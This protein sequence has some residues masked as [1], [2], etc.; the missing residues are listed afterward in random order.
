MRN[1][2][3]EM[4]SDLIKNTIKNLEKNQIKNIKDVY[5]S[6][7]CLVT[8][9]KSMQNFDKEIKSFLKYKMYFNPKVKKKTDKG[10]KLLNFFLKRSQQNHINLS[11]KTK[12]IRTY[13]EIFVIL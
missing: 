8:F 3:N 2:I 4:V 10:K 6:K 13:Q 5:K 1:L 9:S 11:K 7:N 12:I